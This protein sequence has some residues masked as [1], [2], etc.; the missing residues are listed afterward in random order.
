MNTVKQCHDYMY[1][2]VD[3]FRLTNKICYPI[4]FPEEWNPLI[5]NKQIDTLLLVANDLV[6]CKVNI[7]KH[8]EAIHRNMFFPFFTD[9]YFNIYDLTLENNDIRIVADLG[10]KIVG[11]YDVPTSKENGL[12]QDFIC[13]DWDDK[14][15]IIRIS[16]G[17]LG[18][19]SGFFT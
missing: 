3:L 17:A 12:V 8:P 18:L 15:C 6:L 9:K 16:G 5:E 7:L 13:R 4:T 2:K 19:P 1:A 11:N 14:L 10:G